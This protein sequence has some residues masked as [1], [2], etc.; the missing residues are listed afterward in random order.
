[1]YEDIR[2]RGALG[3]R[4]VTD[5]DPNV[6]RKEVWQQ[7]QETARGNA[8]AWDRF[9]GLLRDTPPAYLRDLLAFRETPGRAAAL[10]TVVS[11]SEIIASTFRGAAMSHGALHRIAH[12]AIAA[13]FNRFGAA[14]NCGEGGEDARRDRGAEWAESRSR[15]RQVAAVVSASRRGIWCTRTNCRSRSARARNPARAATC[16]SPEAWLASHRSW[17]RS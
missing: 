3:A 16:A 5:L 11:E 6:Y 2:H 12:R 15:I 17:A 8:G 4:P 13:A 1:V 10:T 7:L 9:T 14:S